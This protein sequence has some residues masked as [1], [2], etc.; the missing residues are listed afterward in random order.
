MNMIAKQNNAKLKMQ[1]QRNTALSIVTTIAIALLNVNDD[2]QHNLCA[3][4]I[5]FSALFMAA[6]CSRCE[7]Y[8]FVL[9]FL[10]SFFFLFLFLT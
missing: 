6:L 5:D 3:G 4:L 8:I 2:K 9:W 7:H 1:C 10:L